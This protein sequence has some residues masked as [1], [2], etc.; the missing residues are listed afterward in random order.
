DRAGRRATGQAGRTARGRGGP[1]RGVR[2]ARRGGRGD[3]RLRPGG[4]AG[5][6]VAG[7]AGVELD[8]AGYRS[9]PVPR[10][11]EI[12]ALER[13]SPRAG[14]TVRVRCGGGAPLLRRRRGAP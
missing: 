5:R 10:S 7:P 14:G 3:R 9:A 6:G 1:V 8:A 4:R 2:D 11:V 12:S 13:A